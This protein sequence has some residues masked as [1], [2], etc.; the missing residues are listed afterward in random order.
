MAPEFFLAEKIPEEMQSQVKNDELIENPYHF[1]LN[2]F[3][4][5]RR[6]KQHPDSSGHLE[7]SR[8]KTIAE[9][10]EKIGFTD[11]LRGEAAGNGSGRDKIT[12]AGDGG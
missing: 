9:H 12:Q 4:Q 10:L 7:K 3:I 6:E 5:E 2:K 11:N 1:F 8:K